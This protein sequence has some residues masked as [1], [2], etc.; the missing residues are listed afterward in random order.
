MQEKQQLTVPF[1][2]VAAGAIIALAV[3]ISGGK[4][5][6]VP[7]EKITP[8]TSNSDTM[9]IRPVSETDHIKGNPNAKLIL[10]EYSDLECPFCKS[11]HDVMERVSEKYGKKGETAWVYRHFP[12]ENLHPKARTEA[13]ATECAG[14]IGGNEVFWNYVNKI[15]EI[16]PSNNGLDLTL[17]PK[18]AEELGLPKKEFASCLSNKTFAGRVEDDYADGL[19]AGVRGTP[20]TVIVLKK[21][22]SS[23][24]KEKLVEL[25]SQFADQR[26]GETPIGFSADE[27]KIGVSG[28]LP[29]PIW[30]KTI[31]ILR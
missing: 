31:E 1:A 5:T 17:L 10:I 11:F 4:S 14:K 6:P 21:N 30:E 9:E 25:Y 20:H 28:A 23:S 19:K 24:Q 27:K 22:I 8:P 12:I 18:I 16:T 29:Y 15:F 26:T 3:I 7:T 2:I 13:E